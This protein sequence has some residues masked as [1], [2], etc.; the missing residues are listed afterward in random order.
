MMSRIVVFLIG[1]LVTQLVSAD[2][3]ST[4]KARKFQLSYGARIQGVPVGSRVKVW[5]PVPQ[6]SPLQKIVR[7]ETESPAAVKF[8]TDKRYL[9]QIGFFE[10]SADGDIVAFNTVYRVERKEAKPGS[11]TE[12]L[13]A[14][15]K[16]K[17]LAANRLVP[18]DGEPTRLIKKLDRDL[19]PMSK[20]RKLYDVVEAYMSYDKSQPGYGNGD[21]LWACSSKTGNC[22]DFHSLFIS[23][24]RNQDIPAR[25]EIGFPIPTDTTSGALS[26]YH[27]WAWFYTEEKGWVAVD[28]SEADKHPDQKEYFF[29][30]LTP[31]RVAFSIGRDIELQPTANSKP[32]N[33]FVYPHVEVDGVAWPRDK[34]KLAI[35]FQDLR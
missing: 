2:E 10:L 29:G 14:E 12:K 35:R 8:A 6:S 33:Y 13:T 21:V 25:F 3:P 28:I 17:Y 26:G 34:V 30:H 1:L 4:S 22:T 7:L 15:Q 27:C 16:E 31:D 24:A 19:N 9:N 32:L 23:L 18:I 5:F 20:G 11:L